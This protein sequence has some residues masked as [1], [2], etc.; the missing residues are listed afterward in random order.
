MLGVRINFDSIF[1]I[2]SNLILRKGLRV[3][4]VFLAFCTTKL[5]EAI[6]AV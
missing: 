6:K 2:L 5:I 3:E 1:E 4:N